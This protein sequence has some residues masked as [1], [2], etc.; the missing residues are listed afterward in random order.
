M[1]KVKEGETG[2]GNKMEEARAKFFQVFSFFIFN[3][4][5]EYLLYKDFKN[6]N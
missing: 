5:H 3:L 1:K 6:P 4:P 2:V